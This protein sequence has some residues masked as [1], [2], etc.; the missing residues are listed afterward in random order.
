[1][2]ILHAFFLISRLSFHLIRSPARMSILGFAPLIVV[3]TALLMLPASTAGSPT[4]EFI[5]K[6]LM[7][8]DLIHRFGIQIIVACQGVKRVDMVPGIKHLRQDFNCLNFTL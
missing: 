3:R 6:T 4:R 1:M 5:G 7:K 8:L 2:L